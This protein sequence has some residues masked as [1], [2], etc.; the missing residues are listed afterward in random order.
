MR[1]RTPSSYPAG[2][3]TSERSA[4]LGPGDGLTLAAAPE[5]LFTLK[6]GTGTDETNGVWTLFEY[7]VSPPARRHRPLP[8]LMA[9]HATFPRRGLLP[10]AIRARARILVAQ[11][12][13]R[14]RTP[15]QSG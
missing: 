12:H 7:T 14:R 13:G 9:R 10:T 6:T 4:G 11:S 2:G 8:A 3:P 1:C 15:C 5:V